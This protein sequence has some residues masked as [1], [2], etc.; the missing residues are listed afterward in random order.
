MNSTP[1]TCSVQTSDCR[2]RRLILIK[3]LIIIC[4][5]CIN[6]QAKITLICPDSW[7]PGKYSKVTID[8]D[9]GVS[10]GFARFTQEYP[11]GFQVEP[12]NILS[13]DFS[14]T[15]NQLNVVWMDLP[16]NKRTTFSY[17]VKPDMSMDGS[18]DL[19]AK[20]AVITGENVMKVARTGSKKILVHGTGGVAEIGKTTDRRSDKYRYEFRV[21]IATSSGNNPDE[22]RRQLKL[23][24][25][26]K[27]LVVKS[28]QVFKYQVGAFTDYQSARRALQRIVAIGI[29]D[30]FI[31]AYEGD[32]QVPVNE[33]LDNSR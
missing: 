24:P 30:A 16:D 32:L 3:L 23:D 2:M 5:S 7:G 26:E 31:V 18:F 11:E 29:K 13:G 14:W 27:I 19:E 25:E 6:G 28:G 17:Y 4:I 15:D 20:L 8:I 21:Q 12:D 9:F 33:A 1:G 10:G 22:I